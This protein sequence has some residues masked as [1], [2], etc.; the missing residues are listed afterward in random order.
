MGRLGRYLQY[1]GWRFISGHPFEW[2]V[3]SNIRGGLATIDFV[4]HIR[5]T[6]LPGLFRGSGI[7]VFFGEKSA[8]NGASMKPS[9]SR[10]A[11]KIVF[12]LFFLFLFTDIGQQ[13]ASLALVLDHCGGVYAAMIKR[14]SQLLF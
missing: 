4:N 6:S 5:G 8:A 12:V 9:L 10:L 2:P 13:L 1:P 11:V 3:C 14:Q 7:L